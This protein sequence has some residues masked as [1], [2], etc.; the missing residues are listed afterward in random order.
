VRN[1]LDGTVVE[2]TRQGSLARVTVDVAGVLLVA[3]VTGSAVNELA[4]APGVAVVASVKASAVHL[5]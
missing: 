4:L 1:V 2:I 5:C 3:S